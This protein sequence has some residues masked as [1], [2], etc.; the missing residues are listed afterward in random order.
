MG[1]IIRGWRLMPLI[2]LSKEELQKIEHYLIGDN[3]P[4][5]VSILEKIQNLDQLCNCQEDKK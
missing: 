1:Y 2:N 4:I 3:D 5:I